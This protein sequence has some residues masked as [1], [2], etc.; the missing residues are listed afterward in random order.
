MKPNKT[1]IAKPH[2][3]FP[4]PLI[5]D[6]GEVELKNLAINDCPKKNNVNVASSAQL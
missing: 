1:I 2:L 5:M 4:Q 3:A 6:K